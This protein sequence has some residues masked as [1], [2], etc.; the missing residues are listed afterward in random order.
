MIDHRA[1]IK[2]GSLAGIGYSVFNNIRKPSVSFKRTPEIEIYATNWG[3]AGAIDAFCKSASLANYDGI[4]VWT[5]RNEKD[6]IALIAILGRIIL[7]KIRM[8]HL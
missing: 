2:A 5:P 7:R 6:S 8:I 1:F 3:F 4:E